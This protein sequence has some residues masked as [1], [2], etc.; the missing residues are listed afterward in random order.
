VATSAFGLD[1]QESDFMAFAAVHR[2]RDA[3]ESTATLKY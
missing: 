3:V 1:H 2:W